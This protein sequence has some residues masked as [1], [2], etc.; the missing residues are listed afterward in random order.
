MFKKIAIA[1]ALSLVASAAFAQGGTQ[2]Q[3][4]GSAYSN[5]SG[6]NNGAGT[7]NFDA[8]N[9]TKLNL[10]SSITGAGS[11][12]SGDFKAAGNN[13]YANVNSQA[14]NL[15]I[16]GSLVGQLSNTAGGSVAG[17]YSVSQ[18]SGNSNT[19]GA[20]SVA[21]GTYASG[22]QFDTKANLTSTSYQDI[23]L[24]TSWNQGFS[25]NGG[26]Q[27]SWA[28]APSDNGNNGNNGNNNGDNDHHGH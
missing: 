11:A 17:D 26:F 25:F 5:V 7:F 16:G 14:S 20:N 13:G 19:G 15:T 9:T 23:A 21:K 2:V 22:G 28:P 12:V 18:G 3:N 6:Y 27:N 4:T 10:G 1:A 24:D 8:G